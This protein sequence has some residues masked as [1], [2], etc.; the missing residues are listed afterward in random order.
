[1]VVAV[2]WEGQLL[3]GS[4]AA[5]FWT[6]FILHLA[7]RTALNQK[8]SHRVDRGFVDLHMHEDPSPCC[9]AYPV[10][11]GQ[12]LCYSAALAVVFEAMEHLQGVLIPSGSHVSHL[13]RL[14]THQPGCLASHE[15]PVLAT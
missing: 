8:Q 2:L 5:I 3:T 1:M 9:G 15:R 10:Q 4:S 12:D 7:Q 6:V 11:Q 13:M 14:W